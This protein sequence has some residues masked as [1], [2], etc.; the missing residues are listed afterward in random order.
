MRDGR[1]ESKREREKSEQGHKFP[2]QVIRPNWP[3][4]K[5]VLSKRGILT[6]G[7]KFLT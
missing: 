5:V 7:E 1:T 3:N 6:Q 2:P 4:S